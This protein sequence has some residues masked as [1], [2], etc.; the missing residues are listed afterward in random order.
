MVEVY[1]VLKWSNPKR[2]VQHNYIYISI[3]F[4]KKRIHKRALFIPRH[5]SNVI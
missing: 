5:R 3:S 4:F 1:G 2:P